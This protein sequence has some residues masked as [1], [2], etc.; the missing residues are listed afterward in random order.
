MKKYPDVVTEP[1]L[2]MALE[3]WEADG[4]PGFVA[5][6]PLEQHEL[7]RSAAGQLEHT[8]DT[9]AVPFLGR[10]RVV[11]KRKVM[12]RADLALAG[13]KN[14]GTAV[15]LDLDLKLTL[16]KAQELFGRR[17]LAYEYREETMSLEVVGMEVRNRI[18]RVYRILVLQA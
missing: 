18:V 11:T 13:A 12:Q 5:A 3:H 6:S 16:P 14:I 1:Q 10:A 7:E 8:A 9:T 4:L 15:W 2:D 17:L